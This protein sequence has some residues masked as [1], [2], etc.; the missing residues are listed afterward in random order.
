MD[1]GISAGFNVSSHLNDFRFSSGDINLSLEPG[2]SMNYQGGFIA[3]KKI[4]RTLRIQAEPS[5]MMLGARYEEPFTL[6]GH[7]LQTESQTQI[8]SIQIPL[9]LQLTTAP[10]QQKVYGRDQ[11]ITTYH[12][13]G[14][15]FGGYLV[16]ARFSGTNT[17]APLGVSFTG[18]FSNDVTSQY[19]NFDGGVILGGGFEY[20]QNT[21]IGLEARGQLSLVDTGNA[22]ELSFNPKNIAATLAVYYMF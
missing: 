11:A 4:N 2:V 17:G 16:D 21:R 19:S 3:R 10:S 20:G 13:T 18:D 7:N 15:M 5:L 9:V 1:F 22:P 6:R 8:I 12:L 14:G